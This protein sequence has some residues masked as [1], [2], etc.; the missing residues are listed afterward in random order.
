MKIITVPHP[1]LRQTADPI[2]KLD[3]KILSFLSQLGDTLVKKDNPK[4]VGLAGP[5][6]DQLWRAFAIYLPTSGNRDD[7]DPIL[8]L[9]INPRITQKSES[10]TFGPNPEEP[11]LEGCLSIP[12]I[13]GPVPRHEWIE[14]EFEE[15]IDAEFVTKKERFAAF[16]A[17]VV[18]HEYDHLDGVLFI[19]YAVEYDLPLYQEKG[20]NMEEMSQEM[21]QAFYH[22]TLTQN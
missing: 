22:Q 8:R 20:K 4:G 16:A 2:E 14:L 21:I 19:D 11:I 1:T 3:K 10:L 6:V 9:I 5:Q 12:G 13:Y 17:R 15:L 18:Q 7:E